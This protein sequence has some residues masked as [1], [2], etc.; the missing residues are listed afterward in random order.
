MFTYHAW[1]VEQ[2]FANI[3]LTA[4]QMFACLRGLHE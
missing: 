2:M 3:A 1:I 4:E